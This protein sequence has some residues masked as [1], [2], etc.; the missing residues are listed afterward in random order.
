[1]L[2]CLIYYTIRPLKRTMHVFTVP[3]KVYRQRTKSE[4]DMSIYFHGS[5]KNVLTDIKRLRLLHCSIILFKSCDLEIHY[6]TY[7]LRH[8]M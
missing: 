7:F 1:M 6:T 3:I 5:I 4:V 8:K 2:D